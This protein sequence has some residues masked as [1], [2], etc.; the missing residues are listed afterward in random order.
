MGRDSIGRPNRQD[1]CEE[2]LELYSRQ[3][4]LEGIG[5]DGQVTLR[6]SRFCIAGMGGLGSAAATQLAAMGVGYLRIID[7]DVVELSNLHRQHLYDRKAV[8]Y[9][10]VEAAARSLRRLNPRLRI[11]PLTISINTATAPDMVRGMDVVVDGLDQMTPRYVLNRTCQRLRVPYVFGAALGSRGNVSTIIPGKTPCLECFYGNLDD[12]KLPTCGTTGVHPSILYMVTGIQVAEA[13]RLA[14][15]KVPRLAGKMLYCDLEDLTFD[16]IALARSPRCPVC[17]E[18]PAGKRRS[19][20]SRPIREICGRKGR[21]V[22]VLTPGADLNLNMDRLHSTV[23]GR[24]FGVTV[25]GKLG[26]TFET[27]RG[28]K[29]SILKS[30]VMIAEG[31]NSKEDAL[32][33]YSKLLPRQWRFSG[34]SG[35]ATGRAPTHLR[36]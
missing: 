27:E 24:G 4:V 33:L 19:V 2:E 36:P 34:N 17:G 15:G 8:G 28:E 20:R 6:N 16:H 13:V 5:Y 11:D 32:Q 35:L 30:G 9:A 23:R 12:D 21:R 26:I 1:L 22:F 14:L 7:H 18:E 29:A 3:I 31:A 25:K 10:K